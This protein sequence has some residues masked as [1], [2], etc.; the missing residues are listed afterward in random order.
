MTY[1]LNLTL[2]VV[3]TQFAFADAPDW[4][5]TS[6]DWEFTSWILGAD[7]QDDGVSLGDSG[8]ILAAFDASG[9]VRGVGV[10]VYPDFGPYNGVTLC[11]R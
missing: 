10:Q 8:D 3:C 7:V 2:L 11:L 9:N 1:L 4:E 6:G 5:Y